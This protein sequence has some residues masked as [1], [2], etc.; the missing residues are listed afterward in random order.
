MVIVLHIL[1]C[2][3]KYTVIFRIYNFRFCSKLGY[4]I[5]SMLLMFSPICF[6]CPLMIL[7][8]PV[9][10]WIPCSSILC[11]PVISWSPCSL[12]GTLK[13]LTLYIWVEVYYSFWLLSLTIPNCRSSAFSLDNGGKRRLCTP[14]ALLSIQRKQV[15]LGPLCL[16][17]Q[18][19]LAPY[20]FFAKEKSKKKFMV[21]T[22]S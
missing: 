11:L 16:L 15:C 2:F 17:L 10:F 8:V 4:H 9:I 13:K 20:F 7:C 6:L 19:A 5:W 22:L 21:V 18:S 1:A 14:L 12:R 3:I